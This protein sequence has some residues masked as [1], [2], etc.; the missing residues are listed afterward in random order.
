MNYS[1]RLASLLDYARSYLQSFSSGYVLLIS[2]NNLEADLVSNVLPV[3]CS[4]TK[5]GI[6]P[7]ELRFAACVED[8]ERDARAYRVIGA[9]VSRIATANSI[10][11][12]N[13]DSRQELSTG[14]A[15]PFTGRLLSQSRMCELGPALHCNPNRLFLAD[16]VESLLE[17]LTR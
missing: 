5:S 7:S 16:G 4:T 15:N 12:E 17:Q 10:S 8:V 1:Q 14:A 3:G 13:V 2:A 6:S 9:A 11:T